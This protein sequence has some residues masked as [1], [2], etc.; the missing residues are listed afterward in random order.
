[1]E[2]SEAPAAAERGHMAV[3]IDEAGIESP[4][5]E[6]HDIIFTRFGV[7]EDFLTAPDAL[8]APARN[9]DGFGF[10]S[11]FG[12]GDDIS[13][14]IDGL[15][16]YQHGLAPLMVRAS[17]GGVRNAMAKKFPEKNTQPN[18]PFCAIVF[19][20]TKVFLKKDRTG[21]SL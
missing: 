13:P 18:C 14:D 8:D 1:M 12:H 11:L 16:A 9:A 7:S 2:P 19:F 3:G 4:A 15:F 10:G 6:I 21:V 20:R 5:A 17:Y